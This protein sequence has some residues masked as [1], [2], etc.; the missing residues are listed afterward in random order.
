[1]G[2]DIQDIMVQQM[3]LHQK[4]NYDH[5]IYILN[6]IY[7]VLL[8]EAV[9]IW[10]SQIVPMFCTVN[11][12]FPRMP[13]C[14]EAASIGIRSCPLTAHMGIGRG[15]TEEL[16]AGISRLDILLHY[17]IDMEMCYFSRF[18]WCFIFIPLKM[19]DAVIISSS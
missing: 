10:F 15:T 4:S 9:R 1:M 13:Q 11:L 6:G 18:F 2:L 17:T 7:C 12:L 5:D 14:L 16:T 19:Y 8:V 3:Y